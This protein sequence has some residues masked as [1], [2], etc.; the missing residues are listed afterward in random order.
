[1]TIWQLTPKKEPVLLG[2]AIYWNQIRS[3]GHANSTDSGRGVDIFNAGSELNLK[4]LRANI[5]LF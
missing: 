3:L 5:P 2:S 1:M 4:R